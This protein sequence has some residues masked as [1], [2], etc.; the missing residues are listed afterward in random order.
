VF[1][2][3]TPVNVTIRSWKDFL[4]PH[5]HPVSGSLYHGDLPRHQDGI[6]IHHGPGYNK[7]RT[8]ME[9]DIKAQS[10]IQNICDLAGNEEERCNINR[11]DTTAIQPDIDTIV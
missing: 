11:M 9:I 1:I 2:K 8:I 4:N 3:G 7:I 10:G 6:N 5:Q